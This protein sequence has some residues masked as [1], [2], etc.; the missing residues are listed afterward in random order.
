MELYRRGQADAA[1]E[2]F[3]EIVNIYAD[4]NV[5]VADGIVER[6][7][8]DAP[9]PYHAR[10]NGYGAVSGRKETVAL[11]SKW[12]SGSGKRRWLCFENERYTHERGLR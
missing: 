9:N 7:K 8:L 4:Y 3:E 12:F 1:E 11:R 2:I 5:K 6:L 10:C